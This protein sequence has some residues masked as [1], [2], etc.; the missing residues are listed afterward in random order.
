LSNAIAEVIANNG[1]QIIYGTAVKKILIEDGFVQGV[2]LADGERLA[3]RAV[4][5]NASAPATFQEMLPQ[6]ALP[7]DFAHQLTAYKPSLASFIVWLGLK[8]DITQKVKAFSTFISNGLSPDE[9]YELHLKGDIE[10]GSFGVAIYDNIFKAYSSPGT[11]TLQLI[12]LC[13]YEPWRKFESDYRA[14]HKQAYNQEKA[15]WAQVLIRRAEEQLIPGL[16][17]MIEVQEAATPLTNWRYTGNTEGAIY[18]YE[19]SMDNAFMNRIKNRTPLKGLYLAS[20]W[21][22]PGGGYG[23]VFRAG[24]SAF[25]AIMK[26]WGC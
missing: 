5:S 7:R 26:D 24:Q 18:G 17:S 19:Q 6:N 16:S 8:R 11:S 4:V 20:A 3:A 9:D 13:A 2:E 10:K 14:G 1:G 25:Q 21:G 23:G 22:N 12:F 15:H